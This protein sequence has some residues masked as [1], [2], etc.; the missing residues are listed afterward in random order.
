VKRDIA[1]FLTL[2]PGDEFL[3]LA[4]KYVP[5]QVLESLIRF[6]E[7]KGFIRDLFNGPVHDMY[8]II[9]IASLV[10]VSRY[11]SFVY[12]LIIDEDKSAIVIDAL[13][14]GY[15]DIV[16]LLQ[17]MDINLTSNDIRTI[18]RSIDVPIQ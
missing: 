15:D 16:P 8:N 14:N 9:V 1:T 7:F 13:N 12:R 18:Q 5:K 3:D 4:I 11:G 17:S 6:T 2:I 10:P